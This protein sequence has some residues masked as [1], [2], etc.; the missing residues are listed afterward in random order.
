MPTS[1]NV[2]GA[3][4]NRLEVR[5]LDAG[6]GGNQVLVG[7]DLDVAPGEMVAVVGHNG[8]GKSTLLRSIIGLLPPWRGEILLD[9]EP[10]EGASPRFF[11]QRGVALVPQGGGVFA[12]LSVRENLVVSATAIPASQR[13]ADLFSGPLETFPELVPLLGR[14]AGTLSGGERQMLSLAMGLARNPRLLLLDEPSLGL[15]PALTESVL[16][17][18]RALCDERDI[19]MV[20]VEQKVRQVIAI[21][22]RVYVLRNGRVAHSGRASDLRDEEAL[23]DVY[24]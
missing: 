5:A 24:L 15:S 9:G 4:D 17:C 14:R 11:G 22:D 18:L 7:V 20:V 13:A 8:A 23:V 3:S 16:S 10:A 1:D 12:D 2:V 21:A 19:G 6:Y